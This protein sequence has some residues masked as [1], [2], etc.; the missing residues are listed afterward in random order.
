MIGEQQTQYSNMGNIL[1]TVGSAIQSGK[2]GDGGMGRILATSK[3]IGDVA[4]LLKSAEREK[5]SLLLFLEGMGAKYIDSKQSTRSERGV[6][7]K[8]VEHV[9][10]HHDPQD[11][12]SRLM[13]HFEKNG[14]K[15]SQIVIANTRPGSRG[16][17]GH[18]VKVVSGGK[19]HYYNF[20]KP[21]SGYKLK[22]IG[23]V[24]VLWKGTLDPVTQK[25]P[26]GI[27]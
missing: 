5:S 18:G 19:H 12:T 14:V 6:R 26:A 10:H 17:T 22:S 23:D 9:F 24:A 2:I 11:A 7:L 16:P 13:S 20:V 25:E 27:K 21:D 8:E 3:G 15:A 1:N 4:V